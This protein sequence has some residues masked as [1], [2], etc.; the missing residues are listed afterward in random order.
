MARGVV[1]HDE[2][3]VHIADV[4]MKVTGTFQLPVSIAN[5][6][7]RVVGMDDVGQQHLFDHQLVERA[8]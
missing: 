2:R 5:L 1:K 3:M 7:G 6:D 8:K 4:G